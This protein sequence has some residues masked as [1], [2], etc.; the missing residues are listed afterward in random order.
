MKKN[1]EYADKPILLISASDSSGAA[2]MQ[3]DLRVVN[4]LGHPA[5]CAL[6][7]MTVQGERG[8][9]GLDP[10]SPENLSRAVDSAVSD[11]PGVRA[12]KIGLITGKE[13]ALA[14]SRCL[15]SLRDQGIPIV[16]DPVMKSTPGSSLTSIEAKMILS[17]QILP[18]STLVTPNREELF[19]LASLAGTD[20]GSEEEMAAALIR[21]GAGAVLATGGD[22]GGDLCLDI[23]YRKG[24]QPRSFRHPRIGAGPTR[25]TGCA[26]SSALSVYLGRGHSLEEAAD[27]SIRY[28]SERIARASQVGNWRLLFPGKAQ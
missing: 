27:L 2:G 22:D 20:A 16:I 9:V 26:L 3:V 24:E 8:L 28:V 10:A 5:R 1:V 17:E 11:P 19:E 7:A 12:A 23:L 4:D 15:I 13:T 25:G 21:A 14:V 6:T 18:L